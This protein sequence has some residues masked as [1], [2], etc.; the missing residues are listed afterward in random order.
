MFLSAIVRDALKA[1]EHTSPGL[2]EL[3]VSLT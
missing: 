3:S 2:G 1:P